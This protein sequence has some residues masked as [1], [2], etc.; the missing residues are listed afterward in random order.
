MKGNVDLYNKQKKYYHFVVLKCANFILFS[1]PT[2]ITALPK[3]RS[4]TIITPKHR[5]NHLFSFYFI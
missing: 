3:E 2:F 1:D 5:G 4:V